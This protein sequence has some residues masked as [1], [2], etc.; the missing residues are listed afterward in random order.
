VSQARTRLPPNKRMQQAARVFWRKAI[1][2][3]SLVTLANRPASVSWRG[4]AP[5]LMRRVVRR[6]L[7]TFCNAT[8][9]KTSPGMG[10]V[11]GVGEVALFP[12]R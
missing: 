9:A 11:S 4:S 10:R 12:S 5:Q 2:V 1:A 6:L 7:R 8:L 3:M